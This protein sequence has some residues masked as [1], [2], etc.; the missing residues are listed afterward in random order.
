MYSHNNTKSFVVNDKNGDNDNNN[1]VD[2]EK[3]E[4]FLKR[5]HEDY[6]QNISNKKIDAKLDKKGI[7]LI[8]NGDIN[9]I[10]NNSDN[11]TVNNENKNDNNNDKIKKKEFKV[12]SKDNKWLDFA[13]WVQT[14]VEYKNEKNTDINLD[15]LPDKKIDKKIKNTDVLMDKNSN[16]IKG[17]FDVIVD[18]ANIGYYKQNF[19]GAPSHIDYR[20]VDWMVRQLIIRYV[21]LFCYICIFYYLYV[22]SLL[23]PLAG[24]HYCVRL[25]FVT[26][27]L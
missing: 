26:H 1:D 12:S 8:N 21:G 9:H 14:L 20:Q 18:G 24:L 13:K 7:H 25:N 19:A 4:K 22:D 15:I 23:M 27:S 5:K 10:N 17:N 2:G 16:K 6:N 3:S 11:N